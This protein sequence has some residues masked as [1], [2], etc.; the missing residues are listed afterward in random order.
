MVKI[1]QSCMTE[2]ENDDNENSEEDADCHEGNSVWAAEMFLIK[3]EQ[4][5][6]RIYHK[7]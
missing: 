6:Q 4:F 1:E 2:H 5:L 3:S 7:N